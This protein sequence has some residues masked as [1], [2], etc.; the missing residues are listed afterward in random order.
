MGE[1]SGAGNDP[2]I[3]G[4]VAKAHGIKG[5]V[6]VFPY[7]GQPENFHSYETILIA[8]G[9]S[10][11]W[12]K[13]RVSKGRVLGK[14][15]LLVLQ[16]CGSRNDAED[17]VG[18]EVSVL[19]KDLPDLGEDEFYLADC[20]GKTVVTVDGELVGRVS[21]ILQTGGHDNIIV[22]DK[23]REYFIPA[24]S[25]FMVKIDNDTITVALPQ[26]LLDINES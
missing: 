12:K 10:G 7:S 4:K 13:Y 16:E 5:E 1:D 25:D 14:F 21:G 23:G 24:I 17:L 2:V 20:E 15:A 19:R 3:L 6:K 9:D 8:A 26:G 18:S 22:K 11:A